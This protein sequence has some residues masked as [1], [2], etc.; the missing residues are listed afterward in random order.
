LAGL[1]YRLWLARTIP[2]TND[3]AYYWD[4]GQNLQWSYFDH[5]PGVSWL[6]ALSSALGSG[7]LAVRFLIPWIHAVASYL[8]LQA[9]VE[10]TH[11]SREEQ[12]RLLI[13]GALA[14][15]LIPGLSLW[16]IFALPDAG[17]YLAISLGLWIVVR[18]RH[19]PRLTLPWALAFGCSLGLAGLFK[20]HALPVG[21]GLA[22]GLLWIRRLHLKHDLPFWCLTFVCG[23]VA[24]L[25]VWIWNW[26]N[27]FASFRF[28]TQHGFG[29][30]VWDWTLGLRSLGLLIVFLGPFA[31]WFFLQSLCRLMV[32]KELAWRWLLLGTACPLL[33][34]ISIMSFGKPI[35]MHWLMPT[36]WM[37]MPA[38]LL[39]VAVKR[40]AQIGML[41]YGV[42]MCGLLPLALGSASVRNQ[43]L[44]W[45][46]GD[47]GPLSE[48]TLWPYLS[49]ELTKQLEGW[50]AAPQ[51]AACPTGG[52]RAAWRWYASAQLHFYKPEHG[53]V[54]NLD[55]DHHSYYF[56]RD[57]HLPLVGC[58]VALVMPKA[59]WEQSAL[60][61][62]GTWDEQRS[63]LIRGH[64]QQAFV[65]V[66]GRIPDRHPMNLR[67][68]TLSSPALDE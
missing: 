40:I 30:A 62:W 51:P 24:C 25:P 1:C 41:V 42:V 68:V 11:V 20:Y 38:A 56:Y 18:I 17:L 67:V 43:L 31:F 39:L 59:I 33:L 46:D 35:L 60:N 54:L 36:F 29:D 55:P 9:S 64:E 57:R 10:L 28:Q 6:T 58:Q 19:A 15:Q 21:G 53:P 45:G 14:L 4:W 47:P 34:L 12:Q 5:P 2:L 32:R 27:D 52:Y 61:Q 65:L 44:V 66:L 3:E 37:L 48:L 8:L 7:F 26:Q 13:L 49:E 22:L 63:L 16:G 23:F 50:P